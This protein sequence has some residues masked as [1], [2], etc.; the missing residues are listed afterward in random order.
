MKLVAKERSQPRRVPP[1]SRALVTIDCILQVAEAIISEVGYNASSTEGIAQVAG[2]SVGSLYQYFPNKDAIA[3]ALVEKAMIRAAA[4]IR[5]TILACMDIPIE[6]GT[7]QVM[8][9]ILETR[10]QH[11]FVFSR[12]QRGEPKLAK[13]TRQMTPE[14]FLHT[15]IHAYYIRHQHEIRVES[16]ETAMFVA[17]LMV[18]GAISAHIDDTKQR[19]SDDELV[20]QLSDALLKYLTR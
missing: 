4:R 15:T 14:N 9:V 19:I 10:R 12:L 17:E 18:T 13:T 6:R 7:P 8:R 1:Q 20:E 16:L 3:A 2:V 11:A 5:E